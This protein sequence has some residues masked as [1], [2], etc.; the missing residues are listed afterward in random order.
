[1]K[2]AL[3]PQGFAALSIGE[4]LQGGI[5]LHRVPF[6]VAECDFLGTKPLYCKNIYYFCSLKYYLSFLESFVMEKVLLFF[7]AAALM[8]T[9]A[10]AQL[11]VSASPNVARPETREMPAPKQETAQMRTPG[12]PVAK[13]LSWTYTY[14]AYYNRPAGMYPGSLFMDPDGSFAGIAFA[15]YYAS[16]PYEPYIMLRIP[17][18]FMS[19]TSTIMLAAVITHGRPSWVR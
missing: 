14:E 5:M 12:T 11:K 17:L 10:S 1:M 7:V 8:A 19:G 2:F 3:A 16:K 9:S 15:P 18:P 6:F 4:A 13:A